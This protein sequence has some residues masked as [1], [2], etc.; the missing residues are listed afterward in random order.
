MGTFPD[1]ML[2]TPSELAACAQVILPLLS[3]PAVADILSTR[4]LDVVVLKSKMEEVLLEEGLDVIDTDQYSSSYKRT[5]CDMP[6]GR[7][8]DRNVGALLIQYNRRQ[9]SGSQVFEA[10]MST[11]RKTLVTFISCEV[12]GWQ[13]KQ[14]KKRTVKAE[15]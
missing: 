1:V 4:G 15:S 6:S 3:N 8:Q 11:P 9:L 5:E 10:L 13:P 7:E 12:I 14:T 2:L